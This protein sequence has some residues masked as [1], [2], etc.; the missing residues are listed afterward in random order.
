[1]L[2]IRR[3]AFYWQAAGQ[4]P[5][6]NHRSYRI[7]RR[8]RPDSPGAARPSQADTP[9]LQPEPPHSTRHIGHN[10]HTRRLTAPRTPPPVADKQKRSRASRQRTRHIQRR[11]A[12]R[13]CPLFAHTDCRRH[14]HHRIDTLRMR[15]SHPQRIATDLH[16]DSYPRRHTDVIIKF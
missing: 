5:R 16:I 6:Q 8:H 3:P 1:M 14:N 4:R 10:R 7:L 15:R 13:C 9:R 12:R 2:Q 11:S